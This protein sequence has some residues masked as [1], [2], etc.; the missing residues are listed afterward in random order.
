[1]NDE[2]TDGVES[3]QHPQPPPEHRRWGV[4]ILV[5]LLVASL[6]ASVALGVLAFRWSSTADR[7]REAA[8]ASR[9]EARRLHAQRIA[10]VKSTDDLRRKA[11]QAINSFDNL[12]TAVNNVGSSQS[13]V[14]HVTADALALYNQGDFAA[15][16]AKYSGD[17]AAA[18]ADAAAKTAAADRALDA[19]QKALADLKVAN[20]G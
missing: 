2:R 1:M 18:V 15:A 9:R 14:T 7:S 5:T 13:N 19:L 8:A 17:D 11:A 20:G 3:D 10:A 12:N 16:R 4:A 6:L